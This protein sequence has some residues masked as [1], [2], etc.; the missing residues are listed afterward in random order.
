[1]RIQYIK[2]SEIDSFK[3]DGCIS[4]SLN[5]I[6]YAYSW[7]L[8]IVAG[9]WDALVGDDYTAVFPLVKASKYGVSYIYQP[10]FAQ[11]LGLFSPFKV[12]GQILNVFIESI[13][14]KYRYQEINFNSFNSIQYPKGE[15]VDRVTYQ[16]DLIQPYFALSSNFNEN[17]RRNVSRAVAMDVH[18]SKRLSLDDFVEF[19]TKNLAVPLN[20]IH[21]GMLRKIMQQSIEKTLGEVYAAYSGSNELCAAAFFI[22][23]NGKVIYL[24]A[25]SSELGKKNRAMFALVDRFINDHSESHLV[26]DFEGSSIENIARFYAGY[27]ASRC[28]YQ[29]LKINNLPWFLKPFKR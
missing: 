14:R 24:S 15:I 5:G 6:V 28:T 25:A 7:Y 16:L 27:G 13:P 9:E 26:L 19:K 1:V 22:R 18:V 20:D 2:H 12:D 10:L 23:S 29:Q 3:W 17:T 8:D 4:R 21:L 11:Q